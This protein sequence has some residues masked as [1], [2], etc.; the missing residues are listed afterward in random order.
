MR[1][2]RIVALAVT[3]FVGCTDHGRSDAEKHAIPHA[4]TLVA[5]TRHLRLRHSKQPYAEV[6]TS[7]YPPSVRAL[8]PVRI[9]TNTHG[10]FIETYSVFVA[11]AG[12]FVRHDPAFAPPRYGGEP[13]FEPVAEKIFWYEAP[14]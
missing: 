8:K 12:V 2:A 7:E 3:V 11:T 13:F 14:G 10:V 4:R 1:H 9:W 5:A 6:P